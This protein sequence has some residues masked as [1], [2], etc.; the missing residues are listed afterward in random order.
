MVTCQNKIPVISAK[1]ES[2][3][4]GQPN[5][6]LI[7]AVVTPH[8]HYSVETRPDT[9]LMGYSQRYS[10]LPLLA[11]CVLCAGSGSKNCDDLKDCLTC[12][13][14]KSWWPDSGCQW[15]PI[16]L[17][18][19][20]YISTVTPC[21]KSQNVAN[22]TKCS[23]SNPP[24]QIHLALAGSRKKLSAQ[25]AMSVMWATLGNVSGSCKYGVSSDALTSVALSGPAVQYLEDATH[26]HGAVMSPLKAGTEYF[27]Q[28]GADAPGWSSV[29]SF[30]TEPA[31]PSQAFTMSVFGD[32]GF[33]G[34][35]KR[36][37]ILPAVVRDPSFPSSLSC[38]PL[39]SLFLPASSALYVVDLRSKELESSGFVPLVLILSMILSLLSCFGSRPLI[40]QPYQNNSLSPFALFSF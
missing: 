8:S 16:D 31:N 35:A 22:A 12:T 27:Y 3:S 13:A 6:P 26:H 23:L 15:C 36:P 7:F 33:E 25:K 38:R 2:P 24:S 14:T 37:L 21:S 18:C 40:R 19:H 39:L 28:V 9:R 1:T 17:Q 20:A 4:F 11:L 29:L 5:S 10:I 34:S 32:L 30:K